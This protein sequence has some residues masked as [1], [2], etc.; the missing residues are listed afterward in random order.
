MERRK[1]PVR[2]QLIH[3]RQSWWWCAAVLATAVSLSLSLSI[4]PLW[5]QLPNIGER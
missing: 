4:S 1:H 3:G 2:N 5:A